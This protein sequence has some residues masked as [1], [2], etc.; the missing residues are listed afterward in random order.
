M[1][2]E[3]TTT[4]ILIVYH[5]WESLRMAEGG[6]RTARTYARKIHREGCCRKRSKA[7][8]EKSLFS[9]NSEKHLNNKLTALNDSAVGLCRCRD[10]RYIE[11]IK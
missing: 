11:N 4:G 9:H 6:A 7:L 5:P 10:N 2:Q 3:L 1:G 8:D